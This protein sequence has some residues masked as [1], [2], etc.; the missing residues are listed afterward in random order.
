V[1]CWLVDYGGCSH[2]DASSYE[3]AR[4][5]DGCTGLILSRPSLFGHDARNADAISTTNK[6]ARSAF[7]GG[8]RFIRAQVWMR[9]YPGLRPGLP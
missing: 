5:R 7:A 6:K 8:L 1:R 2:G 9:N 4:R 3:G